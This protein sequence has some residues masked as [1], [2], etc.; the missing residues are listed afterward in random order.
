MAHN[1]V[2]AA[3]VD[4][5]HPGYYLHWGFIQISLTN[6]LVVIAMIIVFALALLLPFPK[7]GRQD[8]ER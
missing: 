2:T 7:G 3:P 8:D 1:I 6:F 5:S 4:L